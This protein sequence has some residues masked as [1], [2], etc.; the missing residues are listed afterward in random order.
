MDTMAAVRPLTALAGPAP[1]ALKAV[2]HPAAKKRGLPA[3]TWGYNA[4]AGLG[5][6]HTAQVLAPTRTRLPSGTADV[7]GGLNFTVALTRGGKVYAWGGNQHGQ[8]GDGTTS[9]RWS[10]TRVKLPKGTKIA[11]IAVGVDHVVATTRSGRLFAWG[12]NHRGQLGDGTVVDRHEPVL[13][14]KRIPGSVS[15]IAAGNG[16]SAAVT[17]GGAVYLWGRNT[18]G[19][20][21]RRS[22]HNPALGA[23]PQTRPARAV[24]PKGGAAVAVAAGNRHVTVALRDGRLVVFGL[25]AAGRPSE[26]TIRLRSAWGRPMRLAAG[27]DFTLVLTSRHQLLAF[28]ANASGQLGVG[29]HVNRFEPV[30]VKLPTGQGRVR[31]LVAHAR[32]GAALTTNGAVFTWG[33]GNVGQHGAGLDAKALALRPTPARVKGLAGV[34]VTGLHA[35]QHHI[36]ARVESGPA[37][38]KGPRR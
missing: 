25:D 27:E 19:Q 22:K 36:V 4:R 16:I 34:R 2:P 31:D 20:L 33:D 7:Q 8:L 14:R 12:H 35:G 29:D 15:A 10:P 21:G 24:L 11:A 9:L 23:L 1:A 38:P 28:G 13:L 32:G 17:A 18:F 3:F 37:A 26:G 6:G 30:A 5:L